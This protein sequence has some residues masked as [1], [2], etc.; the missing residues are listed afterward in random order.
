MTGLVAPLTDPTARVFSAEHHRL[1]R[2][3]LDPPRERFDRNAPALAFARDVTMKR[4]D[5]M[6]AE[7]VKFLYDPW[8]VAGALNLCV[9]EPDRGKTVLAMELVARA[10]RGALDGDYRGVALNVLI[11]TAEDSPE[12]TLI[13]RLIAAGA[14]LERIH[15]ASV[16]DDGYED[17][18]TLPT[19]VAALEYRIRQHSIGLLVVDPVMAH[20]DGKIDT[21]RDHSMRRALAPL[22]RLAESTGVTVLAIAHLNKATGGDFTQRVGSSVGLS[23]AVRSALL[24]AADP[25]HPDDQAARVLVHGK[26]NLSPAA[27]SRRFRLVGTVAETTPKIET[28]AIAWGDDCALTSADVLRGPVTERPQPKRD[29]ARALLQDM[30]DAGPALRISIENAARD[31]DISWRTVETAKADLGVGDKQVAEPGKH[32]RGPSWWYLP[33]DEPQGPQPPNPISFADQRIGLEP[34]NGAGSESPNGL[35]PQALQCSEPVA[36]L[37]HVAHNSGNNEWY[38]PAEYVDAARATMG[39]IDLD[40]ASC[41][42]ANAVVGAGRYFA[43]ADNGLAYQWNGRVWMNPPYARDLVPAFAEKLADDLEAGRVSEACVLVNNA[44]ET[45]WFQSLLARASGLCL[46]SG[47]VKFWHPDRTTSAPL[48]GQVIAYFGPNYTRFREAF[49]SLGQV[50]EI[51]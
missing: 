46:L 43:E 24:V 51:L 34:S 20:I 12:R 7:P 6:K 44:T 27:P 14:W 32:G 35:G 13:P 50:T 2:E 1:I 41:A 18:L 29:A 25:E 36:D 5:K 17:G 48:Q 22:Y 28:V 31:R 38:T 21:H 30:L 15:F 26:H 9:G 40:P 4:A 42:E 8:L 11:S 3:C 16:E 45:A 39:G 23:G 10:T 49:G 37:P 19:D 33:G 47:R